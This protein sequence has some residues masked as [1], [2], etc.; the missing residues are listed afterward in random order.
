MYGLEESRS[1]GRVGS[2]TD[3]LLQVGVGFG[4]TELDGAYS[5]EVVEVT[6]E[7]GVSGGFGELG[8]GD[9]FVGLLVEVEL[10]VVPEEEVDECCLEFGVCVR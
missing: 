6:G 9:E 8:F 10:E 5:T 3:G 4:V 7:L 2:A 1:E